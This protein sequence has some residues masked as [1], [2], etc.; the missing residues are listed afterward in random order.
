MMKNNTLKHIAYILIATIIVSVVL[1][2]RYNLTDKNTDGSTEQEAVTEKKNIE[3]TTY[4]VDTCYSGAD[5]SY[6]LYD[7]PFQKTEDYVM[8]KKMITAVTDTE[9]ETYVN[10]AEAYVELLFG[11]NYRDV[12]SG[13]EE[14][15]KSYSAFYVEEEILHLDAGTSTNV[16]EKAN[17]LVETYVDNEIAMDGVF[18]TDKSLIYEDGH[19]YY[20]RGEL[21]ITTRNGDGAKLLELF[22]MGENADEKLMVE[23]SFIPQEK[24]IIVGFSILKRIS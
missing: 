5:L 6:E 22:G 14:F 12:A 10:T 2:V 1:L 18:K 21:T 19:I 9:F 23:F 11:N 16:L 4:I 7:I 20:L 24:G 15:I 17:A 8:N 3:D 13:S